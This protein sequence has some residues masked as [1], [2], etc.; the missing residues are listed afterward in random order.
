M[1]ILA[2]KLEE[3]YQ[4]SNSAFPL[5]AGFALTIDSTRLCSTNE[6]TLFISFSGC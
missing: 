6:F 5:I 1:Q 4:K 3:K 2:L